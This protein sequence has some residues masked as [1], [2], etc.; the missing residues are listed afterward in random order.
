MFGRHPACGYCF[1][2]SDAIPERCGGRLDFGQAKISEARSTILIDE[3]VRLDM[4]L[5]KEIMD[6]VVIRTAFKSPCTTRLLCIYISPRDASWSCS[7]T[8]QS[9]YATYQDDGVLALAGRIQG[10]YPDKREHRHS[11]CMRRLQK[12]GRRSSMRHGTGVYVGAEDAS[13]RLAPSA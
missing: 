10:V 4:G 6:G 9:M 13:R 2:L 8:Y 7:T 1:H 5:V 12:E 3:Y 11:P